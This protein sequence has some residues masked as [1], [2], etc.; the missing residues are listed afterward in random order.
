MSIIKFNFKINPFGFYYSIVHL[1]IGIF[2]A[3][4]LV[5]YAKYRFNCWYIW[6]WIFASMIGD[7]IFPIL[8]RCGS[9]FS[10]GD[11]FFSKYYSMHQ[12]IIKIWALITYY[13]VGD[14]CMNFW[15]NFI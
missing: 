11:T 9:Q 12:I 2:G 5:D 7:I 14:H 1:S 4:I 8:T 15:L 6:F 10:L 3:K 13:N